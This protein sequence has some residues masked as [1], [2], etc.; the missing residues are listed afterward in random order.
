M[1]L[2]T[3][4]PDVGKSKIGGNMLKRYITFVLLL[5]LTAFVLIGFSTFAEKSE[6][7]QAT[8]EFITSQA[9][10]GTVEGDATLQKG[11]TGQTMPV[12]EGMII[13]Q[14]D[15]I[16]T[17]V[18]SKVDVIFDKDGEKSV[19]QVY[20]NS[21]LKIEQLLKN[22]TTGEKKTILDLAV[23]KVLVKAAKLEGE[24]KFE[25]NTPTSIVGVRGTE[26]EVVVSAP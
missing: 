4:L 14:N 11:D 6:T 9:T 19:V 20:A 2:G 16:K 7:E 18:G 17:G 15:S 8:G 21:E 26:F 5:V 10:I 22:Q 24:S 13:G 3:I 25:V 23:G 12:G 1:Q